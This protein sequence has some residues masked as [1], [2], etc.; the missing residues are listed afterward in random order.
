MQMQFEWVANPKN[1]R[2]AAPT[3]PFV[4]NTWHSWGSCIYI[5]VWCIFHGNSIPAIHSNTPRFSILKL[6]IK[7]QFLPIVTNNESRIL[8]RQRTICRHRKSHCRHI[9]QKRIFCR[10]R[11]GL[12]ADKYIL[13]VQID[14]ETVNR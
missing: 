11:G 9:V 2:L 4:T 3:V 1:S 10:L 12:Y 13:K 8:C 5:K 14:I 7:S 6:K